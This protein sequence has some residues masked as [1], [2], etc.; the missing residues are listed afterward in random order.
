MYLIHGRDYYNLISPARFYAQLSVVS[1]RLHEV[2]LMAKHGTAEI[3]G[4]HLYLDGRFSNT[5]PVNFIPGKKLSFSRKI[6]AYELPFQIQPS[7]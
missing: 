5:H 3:G 6:T 2:G 1:H 4:L 7:L